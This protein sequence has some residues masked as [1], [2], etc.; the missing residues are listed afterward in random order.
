MLTDLLGD[1]VEVVKCVQHITPKPLSIEKFNALKLKKQQKQFLKLQQ[2]I[3]SSNNL[4]LFDEVLAFLRAPLMQVIVPTEFRS[5]CGEVPV[6]DE[7]QQDGEEGMKIDVMIPYVS[8]GQPWVVHNYPSRSDEGLC[9]QLL[10][11]SKDALLHLQTR[12]FW[13][14]LEEFGLSN[15]ELEKWSALK[16]MFRPAIRKEY[17]FDARIGRSHCLQWH[18]RDETFSFHNC[19]IAA[20]MDED[21]IREGV[22]RNIPVQIIEAVERVVLA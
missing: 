21:V 16:W 3:E 12:L 4:V 19:C 6:V 9:S 1:P 17:V 2:H 13:R 20:R 15:N 11:W 5:D 14:S 7:V 18:E 10:G 8:W 22:R